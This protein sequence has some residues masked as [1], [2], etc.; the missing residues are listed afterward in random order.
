[1]CHTAQGRIAQ[2]S[3]SVAGAPMAQPNLSRAAAASPGHTVSFEKEKPHC[4]M[5]HWD[6]GG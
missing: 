1:M 6:Q 4:D 3:V 5:S 2:P